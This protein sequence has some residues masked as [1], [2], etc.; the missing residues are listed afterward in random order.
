MLCTAPVASDHLAC[1]YGDE[2]TVTTIDVLII[3]AGQAGLALGYHLQ[4]TPLRFQLVERN[5]HIGDSWRRRYDALVLFTPRAY[6]ALPGLALA[7]DPEGYA[8][9]DEVAD[10]VEAYARHFDLP[11]I[12]GTGIQSLERHACGYRATTH[13]GATIDAHA[14]VLATGAF[15]QPAIP[16]VANGLSAA[17][18]QFTVDTYKNPADVPPGTAL[19]VGDGASGRDIAAELQGSHTVIL[20]TGHRR[21]LLPERILGK[22]TW[23]W[24]DKL[25]IVRLSGATVVGRYIKRADAFPGK[26]N[27]LRQ[28]QR[29]GVRVL[30]RVATAAGT[31]VTFANGAS[32]EVDAVIWATG[33]RDTSDWVAIPEVKDADGTFVQ[34]SGVAPVPHFYFIGRPWQRSRGSALLTGVGDDAALIKD[35]LLTDFAGREHPA[36]AVRISQS[37]HARATEAYLQR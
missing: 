12:V 26:G 8:S 21:R 25:G 16:R 32:A 20:A 22:S 28:L 14:V 10:Y 11:V 15:Q 17:V 19:V 1:V 33:Y 2:K 36:G 23:W 27:T 3:G 29:Q 7:G 35:H 34:R 4:Q 18:R 9:R 6:S 24:L 31:C 13:D 5:A 37:A 30:P